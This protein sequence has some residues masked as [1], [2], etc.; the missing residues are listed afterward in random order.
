MVVYV[1]DRI[2][3]TGYH[4]DAQ[5]KRHPF[6]VKIFRSGGND[7]CTLRILLQKLQRRAC[8]AQFHLAVR[9]AGGQQWQK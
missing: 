6:L 4:L 5:D 3:D 7:A 2:F 1:L 9:H 8:R